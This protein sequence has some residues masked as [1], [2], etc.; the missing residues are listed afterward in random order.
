M[1]PKKLFTDDRFN[2]SCVYCGGS[3]DTRDHVPSR[4]LLDDPMPDNLPVVAACSPC[5]RGFSMDEEYVASLVECVISG[6]TDPANLRR[7]KVAAVLSRNS[8]LRLRIQA[9]GS[10]GATGTPQ[11]SIEFERVANVILKLARGHVFYELGMPQIESPLQMDFA[12]FVSMEPQQ[13]EDF[14]FGPDEQDDRMWPEIGSRAF[15]RAVGASPYEGENEPWV[16]VQEGR[17][18]YR[19]DQGN[20]LEVKMVLSEYLAAWVVW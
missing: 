12:P 5:N 3:P 18:R 14:E 20:T 11:W 16:T 17:Y 2:G 6:S 10:D 1:D 19:V 8:R 4:I 9:G 15:Y 13:R 7:P